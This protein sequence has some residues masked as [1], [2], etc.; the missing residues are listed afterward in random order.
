MP[1]IATAAPV[2]PFPII[3]GIGQSGRTEQAGEA[4]TDAE[5]PQ[6]AEHTAARSRSADASTPQHAPVKRALIC[7]H[8][9][10]LVAAVAEDLI[11]ARRRH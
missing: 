7:I 11:R 10:V 4:E 8:S 9:Q 6:L 3:T 2:A 1:K 5:T